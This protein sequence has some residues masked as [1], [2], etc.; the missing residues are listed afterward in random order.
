MTALRPDDPDERSR[1]IADW[2]RRTLVVPD[3]LLAGR[4]ME[5][6]DWQIDYL[7]D[8]LAADQAG[9]SVARKNGKSSLIAALLLYYCAGP[10]RTRH[11][12][13]AVA[14]L[15]GHLASEFGDLL[16]RVAEASGLLPS[17]RRTRMPYPGEIR[18]GDGIT[19]RLLNSG[20]AAANAMSLDLG[21]VDEMGLMRERHRPVVQSLEHA[22][23]AKRGKL[24]AISVQSE[25]EQFRAL[26]RAANGGTIRFRAHEPPHDADPADESIWADGNPGLGSIKSLESLRTSLAKAVADPAELPQF[27]AM[28]LNMPVRAD[29]DGI[30]SVEDWLRCETDDP[31]PRS[32]PCFVGVD[33]GASSSMTA[34][35]AYWPAAGRLEVRAA[36]PH[37]P[38]LRE[39]GR[40]DGVDDLYQ[41]MAD[42]GELRVYEA[43]H[44]PTEEFV[45]D[46]LD[47]LA[48]CAI[49]AVSADRYRI[50][51]LT[52][53]CRTRGLDDRVHARGQGYYGGTVSVIAWQRAQRAGAIRSAPSLL[54]RS[55]IQRSELKYGESGSVK[56]VVQRYGGRIDALSA[57]VLAVAS[58]YAGDEQDE[59][60]RRRDDIMMMDPVLC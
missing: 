48:G 10:G 46:L 7:R 50:D 11:F 34:G 24:A 32:G 2:A 23:G 54:M 28:A 26:R 41:T 27:K 30:C 38:P 55:A 36:L 20:A 40:L 25:G 56:I 5:L 35:A 1:E 47:G 21:V 43:A 57:A 33:L 15:T 12:R 4:P 22:L 42:A 13:A 16:G 51:E 37:N 19:L 45:A 58:G 60:R 8:L 31:P 17:M 44:T 9:L 53:I 6:Q 29:G 39:R 52:R 49:A 3:G 59:R 18:F 14:S